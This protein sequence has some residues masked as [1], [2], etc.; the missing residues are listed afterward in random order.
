MKKKTY[1]HLGTFLGLKLSV[2]TVWVCKVMAVM[3][4][5]L[6]DPNTDT[7]HALQ[8]QKQPF[9]WCTRG[10]TESAPNRGKNSDHKRFK[11]KT[12]RTRT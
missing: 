6:E 1:P 7:R 10:Q 9:I 2:L 5:C 11:N 8:K 4:H 12:P 3:F